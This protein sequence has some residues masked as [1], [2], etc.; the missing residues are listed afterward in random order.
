MGALLAS[1]LLA[2]AVA[3]NSWAY[4]ADHRDIDDDFNTGEVAALD[5]AHAVDPG[6]IYWYSQ[7][8]CILPKQLFLYPESS[9]GRPLD[10]G[11]CPVRPA[12]RRPGHVRP[13]ARVGLPE[14]DE[15]RELQ[16]G[17]ALT[18]DEH[19]RFVVYRLPAR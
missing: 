14:L 13:A 18:E 2:V 7:E 8:L 1:A 12:G 17:G 16:P 5:A 11:R 19:G 3:E 9:P 4:W 15:L 6:A 10:V